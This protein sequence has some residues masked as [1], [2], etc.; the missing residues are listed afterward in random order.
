[1]TLAVVAI[2]APSSWGA[3]SGAAPST[4]VIFHYGFDLS[5]QAPDAKG[6]NP[7]AAASARKVMARFSGAYIDQSIYGFGANVDPEP[8]PGKFDMS[9][10]A[11]RLSLIERSGG[12]PVLSLYAAP[13]WMRGRALDPSRSFEQPP[14]P[15]Y[16]GAYA[17]LCAH[18]AASF[19]A[20]KYFV[21]WNE[22]K[23]FWNRT[24]REWNYQAYTA[25]YNDVYRA[26]KAVRP[27]AMI[28]GPYAVMTAQ[29]HPV[30]R[31]TS[32]VHGRFGFLDQGMLNAVQYWL[33][34]KT[35]AQFVAVDG[36]TENAKAGRQI[37]DAVTAS[38]LYATVDHWLRSKTALPIWWMESHI[39]PKGW[40]AHQGA[41]AR[42]ATLAEMAASGASVGMQWQPQEQAGWP[43]AGLWTSTARAGGGRPTP[44]T[45]A[46]LEALPV[47]QRG[48]VLVPGQAGGVLVFGDAAGMIAV[49]TSGT[50]QS[51]HASKWKSVL[52]PG[53]VVLIGRSKAGS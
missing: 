44:L 53:G 22:L 18:V 23:G 19:R 37:V 1:M 20:V 17:Q 41:A 25:M 11:G 45:S 29:Q 47:L 48:P 27:T 28:G 43:D 5:N 34:H 6:Q 46:L 51:A 38:T 2:V 4:A 42:V 52:P 49:N 21:V 12:V 36:A 14:A 40:T 33:T 35:G 24:T 30:R 13:P 9:A 10:I 39:A 15:S 26:I 8:A 31:V 7:A 50:K 32:E 3:V 16:Y